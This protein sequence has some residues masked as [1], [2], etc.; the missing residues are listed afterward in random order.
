MID[1]MRQL[2]TKEIPL[3]NVFALLLLS[4]FPLFVG[5]TASA[6]PYATDWVEGHNS[7]ARLL[8]GG[9]P[10]L[11][12]DIQRYVALEIVMQPGWKTYWRQ[13][14]SAGGIPPQLNWQGS[15][16][17]KQATLRFPAPTRMLDST[18]ATI[19]YK[20]SVVL[21]IALEV[22]LPSRPVI[23][24]LKALFGVCREI[25]IPAQAA[26]KVTLGPGN[27]LQSPPELVKALRRVPA[28]R[29]E[30]V[31]NKPRLKAVRSDATGASGG[32]ALIFDVQF[33]GGTAGADLFAESGD[34][35]P[36]AMSEAVAEPS[37]EI[38]RYRIEVTDKEQ[39]RDLAK[40][41]IILTIVSDA[42]ASEVRTPRP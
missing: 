23:V 8:V 14:G 7:K 16:N 42:A 29:N 22:E 15:V 41:G 10:G 18:G 12:G 4:L 2:E 33:P 40:N 27:F 26:F 13:P 34:H 17:L 28:T 35:L 38:I 11:S 24:N 20:K 6:A 3:P 32:N 21:P 31:K 1:F 39:W 19:G 25:C 37:P 30:I 5:A 36:L 9:A